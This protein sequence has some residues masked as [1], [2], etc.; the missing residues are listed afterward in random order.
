MER[1]GRREWRERSMGVGG[2]MGE[3]RL[4]CERSVMVGR[5]VMMPSLRQLKV[6]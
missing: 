3:G 2:I 6:V 5:Y 4:G 1:V